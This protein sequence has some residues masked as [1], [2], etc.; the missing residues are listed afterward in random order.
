MD[1]SR[2]LEVLAQKISDSSKVVSEYLISKN[3][4]QPSFDV[5]APLQWPKHPPDVFEARS[6]L[7]DATKKLHDLATGHRNLLAWFGFGWTSYAALQWISH[8]HIADAVP[9]DRV[10]S[11][12]EIAK[13]A[14]VDENLLRRFVRLAMTQ[15]IFC[16]P[17][18][19]MVAHT[20]QSSMLVK[21]HIMSDFMG[22]YMD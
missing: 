10:V 20:A 16:E 12:T 14:N 19:G 17:R 21:T 8:F 7:R 1:T 5:N 22:I 6:E 4:P 2:P 3:L 13:T 11:Y 18:S 15:D 9:L